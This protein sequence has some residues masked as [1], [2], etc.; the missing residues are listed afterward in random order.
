MKILL[1]I[2][3][4]LSAIVA[5]VTFVIAAMSAWGNAMGGTSAKG[6]EDYAYIINAVLLV[7]LLVT[8]VTYLFGGLREHVLSVKWTAI[9]IFVLQIALVASIFLNFALQDSRI[10]QKQQDNITA[11]VTRLD[12][13]TQA[14]K[15]VSATEAN[16]LFKA[17][18]RIYSDEYSRS[19]AYG[20]PQPL[21]DA[22]GRV[23]AARLL[24]ADGQYDVFLNRLK[25]EATL[26]QIFIS[27]EYIQLFKSYLESYSLTKERIDIDKLLPLLI[28]FSSEGRAEEYKYALRYMIAQGADLEIQY[29]GDTASKDLKRSIEVY[30]KNKAGGLGDEETDRRIKFDEDLF[31]I[32]EGKE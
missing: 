32:L 24:D 4:L 22:W 20:I 6:L 10:K 3:T 23:F 25:G 15:P 2:L 12:T 7:I 31:L 29:E 27:Y 28:N 19:G 30:T 13:L 5:Y 16:E 11:F 8:T 18:N 9:G 17:T 14:R 26:S 1:I 21:V